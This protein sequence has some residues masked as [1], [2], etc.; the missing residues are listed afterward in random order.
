MD[1]R[2]K[3]NKIFKRI[4]DENKLYFEEHKKYIEPYFYLLLAYERSIRFSDIMSFN[5]YLENIN[6]IS[7]TIDFR[8]IEFTNNIEILWTM[9]NQKSISKFQYRETIKNIIFCITDNIN[10]DENRKDNE[11]IIDVKNLIIKEY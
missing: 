6:Y 10:Q 1:Y 7:K 11:L 2:I 8:I 3:S 5:K 9:Y 4:N